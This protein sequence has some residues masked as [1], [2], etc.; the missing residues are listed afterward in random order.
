MKHLECIYQPTLNAIA[1]ELFTNNYISQSVFNDKISSNSD[2][3]DESDYQQTNKSSSIYPKITN[4]KV[5]L[6]CVNHKP[7][8]FIIDH[9]LSENQV[10]HLLNIS[11]INR[12]RFE[13]SYTQIPSNLDDSE[14]VCYNCIKS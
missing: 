9:F 7:N 11:K 10:N 1:Y 8:V 4:G 2:D 12:S 5:D 6:Q 14:R 13:F 3:D